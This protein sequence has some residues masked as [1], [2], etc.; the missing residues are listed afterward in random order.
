VT[1]FG[2]VTI[3]SNGWTT[4]YFSGKGTTNVWEVLSQ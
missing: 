1:G 3:S 2:N 4:L